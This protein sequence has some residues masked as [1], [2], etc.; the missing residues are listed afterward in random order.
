ML[1]AFGVSAND[2]CLCFKRRCN[3][4]CDAVCLRVTPNIQCCT[5]VCWHVLCRAPV[6][7]WCLSRGFMRDHHLGR[8]ADVEDALA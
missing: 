1:V 4:D 5:D 2:V 7:G 6:T 8:E 3:V